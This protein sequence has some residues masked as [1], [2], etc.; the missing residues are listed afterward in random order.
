M[1][2]FTRDFMLQKKKK[3]GHQEKA[4]CVRLSKLSRQEKFIPLPSY[5]GIGSGIESYPGW[6]GTDSVC[7]FPQPLCQSVPTPIPSVT[8]TF[9]HHLEG[10]MLRHLA[11]SSWV[12]FAV[13]FPGMTLDGPAHKVFRHSTQIMNHLLPTGRPP[14]WR[15]YFT[16]LVVTVSLLHSGCLISCLS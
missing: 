1:K 5:K 15:F 10:W 13:F 7:H 12:V 6:I 16:K 8:H 4:I 14:P 9:Y 3:G 11:C 2:A